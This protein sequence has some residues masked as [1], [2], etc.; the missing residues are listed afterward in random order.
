MIYEYL[1]SRHLGYPF[2][3]EFQVIQMIL[4]WVTDDLG[5]LR[6]FGD[7]ASLKMSLLGELRMLC[8]QVIQVTQV[9]HKLK[10]ILS[11]KITHAI[12]VK[13]VVQVTQ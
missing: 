9:T 7:L 6:V 4:I 8:G 12:Q 10:L 1:C 5:G 2:T 11:Y 13:Q 3:R